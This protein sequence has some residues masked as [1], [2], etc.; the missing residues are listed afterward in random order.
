M[1]SLWDVYFNNTTYLTKAYNFGTSLID[2]TPSFSSNGVHS[3]LMKVY[4]LANEYAQA[5]GKRIHLREGVRT[6]SRQVKLVKAGFSKTLNSRHLTGHAIDLEYQYAGKRNNSRD[7]R[8]ARDINKYMQR[9]SRSLRIKVEWGGNWKS[10][11]DGFHWQLPWAHKRTTVVNTCQLSRPYDQRTLSTYVECVGAKYKLP[12]G[13]MTKLC[14]KESGCDAKAVATKGD[15][16]SAVG[17]YQLKPTAARELGLSL[18]DRYNVEKSTHAAARYSSQWLTEG[19]TSVIL[20]MQYNQ[21]ACGYKIIRQYATHGLGLLKCGGVTHKPADLYG[22][23]LA[24]TN[25]RYKRII[26]RERGLTKT[27][28]AAYINFMTKVYWR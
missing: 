9:A 16:D 2:K 3:D 26:R 28:A 17:I 15:P 23:I 25:G 21:G 13:Y 19:V 18:A 14:K 6:K 8:N 27:S 7:W 24:N 20:Y 11:P 5:D 10:F 1:F 22:N 4:T 12:Y